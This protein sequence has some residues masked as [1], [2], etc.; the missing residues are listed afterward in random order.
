M[1]AE[2]EHS[3]PVFLPQI[4]LADPELISLQPSVD[5]FLHHYEQRCRSQSATIRAL[6]MTLFVARC[7]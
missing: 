6:R 3:A 1:G 4:A 2:W 7:T 5:R